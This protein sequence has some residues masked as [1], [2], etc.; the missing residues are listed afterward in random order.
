MMTI[1]SEKEDRKEENENRFTRKEYNYRSFS[2]SFSLPENV[3]QEA[4]EARYEHGVLELTLPK[5]QTTAAVAN[6]R[7]ISVK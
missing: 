1:S 3:N 4:I 2:R 6:T 7:Q 5:K